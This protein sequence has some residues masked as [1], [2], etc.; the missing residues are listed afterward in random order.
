MLRDRSRAVA[1]Q[2]PVRAVGAELGAAA[3]GEQRKPAADRPRRPLDAALAPQ[4]SVTQIPAR[5]RQ[6]VEI[7]DLLAGDDRLR[8][9]ALREAHDRRFGLAG[10]DEVAWSANSSGIFDAVM[11]TNPTFTPRARIS[12][13]HAVSFR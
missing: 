5:K 6:R 8:D 2:N 12:S 4:S 10:D 3:A 9:L 1:R 13:A 7:V 11:P